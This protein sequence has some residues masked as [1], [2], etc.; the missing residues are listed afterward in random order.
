MKIKNIKHCYMSILKRRFDTN[1]EQIDISHFMMLKF[2]G[3][4]KLDWLEASIKIIK[5]SL[6][7]DEFYFW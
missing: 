2:S 4:K 5:N 7:E 1:T 3:K 6:N